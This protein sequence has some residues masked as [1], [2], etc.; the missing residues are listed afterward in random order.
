MPLSRLPGRNPPRIVLR[1]LSGFIESKTVLTGG[2][3]VPF[4]ENWGPIVTLFGIFPESYSSLAYRT[5]A[6]IARIK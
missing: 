6:L 3:I 5:G 4:S 1:I 2:V